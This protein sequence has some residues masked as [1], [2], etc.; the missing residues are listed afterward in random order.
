MR[1]EIARA[2]KAHFERRMKESLPR[3]ALQQRTTYGQVYRASLAAKN[4]YVHLQLTRKKDDERFIVELAASDGDFPWDY[5]LGSPF[6][7]RDGNM[8]FRLPELFREEWQ[9]RGTESSWWC[10]GPWTSARDRLKT[11]LSAG[12]RGLSKREV[13][14]SEQLLPLVAPAVDDAF[15][16]LVDLGIP[17]IEKFASTG[18]LS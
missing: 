4:C 12:S 18:S 14:P 9:S 1:T 8:R 17:F 11:L 5:V 16:K 2:V 10:V 7:V 3:Y 15:Q 13:V 6:N